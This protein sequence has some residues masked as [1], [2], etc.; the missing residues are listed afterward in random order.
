MKME[1]QVQITL[2]HERKE[3]YIPLLQKAE[4]S[5]ELIQEYLAKGDLFLMQAQQETICIALANALSEEEI[6]IN[7]IYVQRKYQAKGYGKMMVDYLSE[8]YHKTYKRMVVALDG[9][10]VGA[11]EFFVKCGFS[12]SHT[13]KGFFVENYPMPIMGDTAQAQD[14]VFFVKTIG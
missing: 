13:Q 11:M 7:L 14:Q 10:N 9:S 4:P 3:Q 5:E 1:E 6:Q 8:C 2:I 12:Y